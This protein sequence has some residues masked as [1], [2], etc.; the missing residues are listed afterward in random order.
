[1]FK[2]QRGYNR[3]VA[4]PEKEVPHAQRCLAYCLK[5][6]G[7]AM[8]ETI[9]SGVS[10]VPLPV[11]R[12][13]REGTRFQKPWR[14]QGEPQRGEA[15]WFLPPRCDSKRRML[16]LHGGAFQGGS[17][18]DPGYTAFGSQLAKK[19]G[20]A[21]LSID[22][23]LAPEH[24]CPAAVED[25]I[26]ALE[27]L[28]GHGPPARGGAADSVAS[29][30]RASE[31]FISGD[32]AGGGLALACSMQAS[33]LARSVVRGVV[34][35]SPWAD[36]TSS[37]DTYESRLWNSKT[38]T[39]DPFDDRQGSL[40][41]ASVYIGSGTKSCFSALDPRASPMF[42]SAS[43]LRAMPRTL[44]IVGDYE[45]G[46]GDSLEMRRRMVSAGHLDVSVSVYDRMFHCHV[47]YTEGMGL[48]EPLHAGVRAVQ[49]M[50]AWI[51]DRS[52]ESVA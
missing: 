7:G 29:K 44:F 12:A 36:L 19:T 14:R 48:G 5:Y 28:V 34:A 33:S 24:K 3:F 1:M 23:R 4:L 45:L 50:A 32:S 20:L 9:A 52:K 8:D 30:Q 42:A 38:K 49:E 37:S 27:W 11:G 10:V 35:I 46:L 17:P 41:M 47:L 25:A 6:G 40:N 26:A 51:K 15:L 13:S 39:G 21:V 18:Q 22:Y 2:R 16:F 31:I 43:Q